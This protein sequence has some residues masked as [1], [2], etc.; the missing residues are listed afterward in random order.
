MQQHA[1]VAQLQNVGVTIDTTHILH[2]INLRVD[3]QRI[4]AVVGAS[5]SGKST[6]LRLLNGLQAPS[7]GQV[8][9]AGQALDTSN[10][11]QVRMNTGYALQQIGLLPHLSARDNIALPMHLAGWLDNDT[12]QRID[13]L[14]ERLRLSAQQL[15]R[16]PSQLSGGQQQRVGLCRAMALQPDLLL[17]D[18]AFSGLDAIT[19]NATHQ[20]FSELRGSEINACLL[21][22]HD[23]TEARKLAD[24]LVIMRA[25]RI[26]RQG[27]CESVLQDPQDDYA[28]E[29]IETFA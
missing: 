4:V 8:L 26:V 24:D 25:G 29:L 23:L 6:L 19:R 17:L 28:R 16:Y 21:V 18:E 2:D 9:R 5:G 11:R 20:R 3:A 14:S 22:T 10:L 15:A 7:A 1:P 12:Q 27:P 13:Q